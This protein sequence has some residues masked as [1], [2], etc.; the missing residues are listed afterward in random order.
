MSKVEILRLDSVTTNDTRATA[1]INTNF[2]N[3]QTVIDTLLSRTNATPNYMD[4]V[5]DMNSQK[6]INTA[7]PTED[8]DVVNLKYLRDYSGNVESLVADATAAAEA[9]L[10]KANNAAA[11]ATSSAAYAQTAQAAAAQAAQDAIDAAASSHD[12]STM[13]SD[14]NLVAVGTDLRL[15]DSSLIKQAI[16]AASSAHEDAQTA[17]D[18]AIKLPE[19]VDGHEYSAKYYAREAWAHM[20]NAEASKDLAVEAAGNAMGAEYRVRGYAQDAEDWATKTDGPVE[21]SCYSAKY[22][23]LEAESTVHNMANRDLSNLTPTGEAK[24]ASASLPS[25]SGHSGEF[26]TTDGTDAS[27]AAVDLSSK[28]DVDLSN[29]NPSASAKEEIT[30]WGIPDYSSSIEMTPPTAGATFTVPYDCEYSMVTN[31]TTGILE[32]KLND[33]QGL[34]ILKGVS[35]AT[36]VIQENRIILPKDTVVYVVSNTASYQQFKI[37]PLKGIENA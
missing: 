2:Y 28:A 5:L 37:T 34:T 31:Y 15:G 8:F 21:G 29:I 19:T 36:N 32:W 17:K 4:T 1:L 9:A 35:G 26:L 23:A 6:I 24:I 11:S 16:P 18:W 10:E 13:L 14:P 7:M 25:Q 27:W 3:I 12:I 30:S 22:W 20:L 33:S